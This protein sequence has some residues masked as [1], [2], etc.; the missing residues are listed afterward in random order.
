MKKNNKKKSYSRRKLIGGALGLAGFG[1]IV[2]GGFLRPLKSMLGRWPDLPDTERMPALF[3]GHGTPMSAIRPNQWT[4]TWAELGPKL[5]KPSAILSISAHWITEGGAMVTASEAP[6]M[7]YDMYG[8]P[9]EL[10][11]IRYPSPGHPGL[12]ADIADKLSSK[13]PVEG[14][15][16]W[17]LDHATWVV[18]KYM[19]PRADV[20]V[21]QLSIDYS[22]PPAFHYELGK[23]LQF[24]RTKGVLIVGSGNIVHNLRIRPGMNNDQ[25]YDWALEFD[26]TMWTRIQEGN[27]QAVADFQK[28]GN[29]ASLSHPTYDHFLPLLYCLGVKT[30]ADQI[31]TFNDNFQWPAVSMRSLMIA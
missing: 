14:D 27:F 28:L 17:G 10:Y 9:P 3:V 24:L 6:A 23:Y 20:P 11:Q 4:Q 1:A 31:T 19:F 22:R 12:A 7:N 18:L 13:V 21:L 30:D 29:A 8:F 16:R 26:H 5:P 25:P 2:S 15:S